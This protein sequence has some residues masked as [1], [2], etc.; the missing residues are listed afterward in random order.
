MKTEIT[1][2]IISD[3]LNM[4]IHKLKYAVRQMLDKWKLNKEK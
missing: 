3:L 2:K 1:S 4:P